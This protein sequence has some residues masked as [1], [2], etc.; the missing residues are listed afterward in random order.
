MPQ[1]R[2]SIEEEIKQFLREVQHIEIE[3]PRGFSTNKRLPIWHSSDHSLRLNDL[4]CELYSQIQ[5]PNRLDFKIGMSSRRML[6]MVS[7]MRGRPWHYTRKYCPN[8]YSMV[9]TIQ[10]WDPAIAV[11]W[12]LCGEDWDSWIMLCS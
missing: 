6:E 5:Q 3:L 8:T 12:G 10:C 7:A 1:T 9:H 2:E 4:G 11:N